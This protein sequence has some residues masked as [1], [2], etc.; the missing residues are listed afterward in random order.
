MISLDSKFTFLSS[1]PV[2]EA[3]LDIQLN[4]HNHP[5]ALSRTRQT[6]TDNTNNKRSSARLSVY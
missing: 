4:N 1:L 3:A 2:K 5:S 6:V